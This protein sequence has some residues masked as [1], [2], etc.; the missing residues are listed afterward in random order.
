MILRSLLFPIALIISFST[1]AFAQ[2]MWTPVSEEDVS[3]KKAAQE[4]FI[5]P[6]KSALF[7]LDLKAFHSAL[8]KGKNNLEIQVPYPDGSLRAFYLVET[9]VMHP[10]LAKRFPEIRTFRGYSDEDRSATLHCD[11]TPYGYHGVVFSQEYS[12]IYIDPVYQDD[13]RLHQAYHRKDLPK[14]ANRQFE[15]LVK[16]QVE[17]S[18]RKTDYSKSSAGDCTLRRYR[19][20][21]ACT[22][23]YADFHGGTVPLTLAAMVTAMVR[24]NGVYERDISVTMQLIPNNDA[25]IFLDEATDPYTNNNGGAMLGQNQTTIDNIIG[26]ANYDIGHVFSTGGGGIASLRSPCTGRKAQGVTGLGQPINDPFTIDY[27]AHEFGHQFGGNHTQNNS[28]Q[29]AGPAGVEPGSASTIM[30]Y[31]GICAPNVQN[32]SD[33]HFHAYNITEMTDNILNGTGSQCDE[34][35]PLNNT[36]PSVTVNQTS[37][38]LPISTPFVLDAEGI[39][40]DGDVLSYCWEQ[41]N[42]ETA[43]MPPQAGNTGGP[44][45]RSISPHAD[46]KRYLPNIQAIVNN[47]TPTWEVLPA[48]SRTMDFRC[49]VR[50]NAQGGGCTDEV[51]VDLNFSASAGPFLVLYPNAMETWFASELRTIEWDVSNTDMAPVNCA[52][53]DILFSTDG[54][55]TYPV[56]GASNVANSG[57]FEITVPDIDSDQVRVM[58]KCSDN[59]FFDI[60]NQDIIIESAFSIT[61]TITEQ[62]VCQGEMVN[63]DFSF[64]S[65]E[66]FDESI[67]LSLMGI[68]TSSYTLS[69]NAVT[70]PGSVSLEINTA[71]LDLGLNT[72]TLVGTAPSQTIT[73]VIRLTILVGDLT[74]ASL[75]SPTEQET[76][77]DIG[78]ALSWDPVD[79]AQ[80][81]LIELSSSPKFA[82]DIFESNQTETNQYIIQSM[83]P[84]N[85]VIFWRVKASNICGEGA[86]SEVKSFQLGGSQCN[87]FAN[88]EAVDIS[89]AEI[90][91][92]TMTL[93]IDNTLDITSFS[94]I[95]DISHTWVGDLE[96]TLTSPSND[97]YALFDRPGFPGS[98]YGCGE[99]DIQASF[100]DSAPSSV[101]DFEEACNGTSPAIFGEYMAI[102]PFQDL[103]G[104]SPEGDWVLTVVDN[105]AQDGGSINSLSL[106]IC[107]ENIVEQATLLE[108]RTLEVLAGTAREITRFNLE[109]SHTN[110]DETRFII[111]ENT[112][113]GTL[114]VQ[115][116]AGE[117][118]DLGFGDMFSQNDINENRLRYNQNVNPN[119]TDFF[120]F[121]VISDEGGWLPGQTFNI[122]INTEGFAAVAQI[123]QE[124]SCHD[125][126]DG[127]VTIQS[128]GGF[129]PLTYSRDDISYQSS[130]TFMD[131]GPGM[132]TFYILDNAGNKI[133]TDIFLDVPP[134]IM[135][136]AMVTGYDINVEVSGGTGELMISLDDINYQTS[137]TFIDPGNGSY[138]VYTID[139]NNCKTT[140]DELIINI[141]ALSANATKEDVACFG[142]DTGYIRIDA[143]GGIPPYNYSIDGITYE[144]NNEFFNLVASDYNLS[145]QDAGGKIFELGTETIL[146][147]DEIIVTGTS[148]AYTVT[149]DAMGGTG[150]FNYNFDGVDNGNVNVYEFPQNGFFTVIVTDEADCTASLVV[151]VST[152][153]AINATVISPS[154]HDSNDGQI[155]LEIDG[156]FAPFMYSLNGSAPQSSSTFSDLSASD[157]IITVTDS[158][159]QSLETM[160]TLD[161]PDPLDVVLDVLEDDA[162]IMVE[163]GTEPYQYSIDGGMTFTN[164]NVFVGL[165]LGDYDVVV[166]DANDCSIEDQFTIEFSSTDELLAQWGLILSPNPTFGLVDISASNLS[167]DVHISLF[168]LE[169][170]K[171][172]EA[173]NIRSSNDQLSHQIDLSNIESGIYFIRIS[174]IVTG[175]RAMLKLIKI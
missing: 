111:T 71:N 165:P 33:D 64:T 55:L 126:S 153:E 152:I 162:A 3:N 39:D 105:F 46:S 37:Y 158:Q 96:A 4:R 131:L 89:D 65:F 120:T 107:S 143:M 106:Q 98:T 102:D 119:P 169:G 93:A 20:A 129:A 82:D 56:I 10:D 122:V 156:G 123:D 157:Y 49:T 103:L 28:C 144:A 175:E 70:P 140:T 99:N 154:C 115:N 110:A 72:I 78:E 84:P 117:Y 52:E 35:I 62:T 69:T 7:Q 5:N 36:P 66:G 167:N 79:K 85:T 81:Y 11:I 53:V 40:I 16:H 168:S 12:S 6:T 25:L 61:P 116:D 57:S 76:N 133:T 94:V 138:T 150:E 97:T 142:E 19:L 166:L 27:V 24:V 160:I 163:G 58:V 67:Q 48:V 73:E 148:D 147:A 74:E 171:L 113:Y 32:N 44:A 124:I 155:S 92:R 18:I 125:N 91:T 22:G 90:N 149:I 26:S 80:N 139:E 15:C 2:F 9:E 174:D 100:Y 118:L 59:I 114:Q 8:K 170:K 38:T 87:I 41:M 34:E 63:V 95:L 112:Q 21:L 23:E 121:D 130:P 29:N 145:V 172:Y 77:I 43:N 141:D 109:A 83:L 30:G 54:G 86:Y 132:Y 17:R 134:P 42:A 47:Q 14:S 101:M 1:S 104:T 13:N 51:D 75:T 88:T 159:G 127:I 164:N 151:Q 161:A 68:P 31:A 173:F 146:Q 45:F 136:N 128:Q 60:S 137:T 108:N 50:D 135:L